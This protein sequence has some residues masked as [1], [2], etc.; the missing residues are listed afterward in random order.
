MNGGNIALLLTQNFE[1][2]RTNFESGFH[3]L[4][5]EESGKSCLPSHKNVCMSVWFSEWQKLRT[6]IISIVIQ[7]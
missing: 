3:H 1:S 5:F 4:L 2:E 6:G 7:T